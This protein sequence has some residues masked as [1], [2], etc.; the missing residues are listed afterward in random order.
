M[1]GETS[2]SHDA[3]VTANTACRVGM[4]APSHALAPITR[5]GGCGAP[6]NGAP[7]YDVAVSLPALLARKRRRTALAVALVV[8]AVAIV[9]WAGREGGALGG[10]E[11]Q[12]EPE[13]GWARVDGE[14][15]ADLLTGREVVNG[16]VPEELPRFTLLNLWASYCQPCLEEMPALEE[17][18]ADPELEV[19][20]VGISLD[21]EVAWAREFQ[22]E[23]E[24]TFPNVFDP[25]SRLQEELSQVAPVRWLPTTFLIVDG[26][27]EWV[28]LGPFDDL[29][30]LRRAVRSRLPAGP[31]DERS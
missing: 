29:A 30:E 15:R 14:V 1:G 21:Q 28:H 31:L 12:D 5:P 17:L 3:I 13:L 19:E 24:V 6:S 22:R 2:G 9:W 26:Q 10:V 7:P 18:D 8:L 4:A 16:E 27:A 20:V 23:V 11:P 25:E